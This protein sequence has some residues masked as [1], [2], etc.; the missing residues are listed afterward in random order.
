MKNFMKES[1]L[2]RLLTVFAV[3]CFSC[4]IAVAQTGNEEP[5]E[6]AGLTELEQRMQKRI[7]ID[8]NDQPI[9]LVIRQL[10]EQANLNY[11]KS[12]NVIGNVTVTFRDVPLEE[13]LRN[14]LD[15]HG[16]TYVPTE[17]VIRIITS[18]EM[19]TKAEPILTET[20]EI[21]YAD[22]EKVVEALDKSK[23]P[24]GSVSFIKGTSYIIV[25]DTESKIR[26]I[27]ELLEK[28]DRITPQI[29]VEARI[30]DITS[31]DKLDLGVDWYAGRRTNWLGGYPINDDIT[32]EKS[33]VDTYLGSN[34]DPSIM[35]GFT[36]SGAG[37]T[38][39]NTL[40][41]LNLGLLNNN[42]DINALL[43]AEQEITEAKLLANPRIL[44]LDNEQ[45]LF[46]IV[47]EHPYV[48][49]TISGNQITETVQFK[50]VGIKLVV[51]P[52]VTREGM[53]RLHILPEFGVKVGQV[54]VS[55]NNVPIVDTRKVDTIALVRDGQTVVLGGMRQK[56]VSKQTN[57]IPLLGDLPLLGGL[58][59]F[60]GED[61]AVTE[62]IV[63]ITPW[64]V[65]QEPV[66]SL[67]EQNALEETNFSRPKPSST[68]A[69]IK[70]AEESS[71]E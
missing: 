4:A 18:E 31:R 13:A 40:G 51:T 16:C 54:L 9:D 58:F 50:D 24:Q 34:T 21:V 62:L 60:D 17:N 59:R 28:I 32:V 7:S 11:I 41:Y 12:P 1:L 52:H 42:I 10:V 53:L 19:V 69:E 36:G 65:P 56:A 20:F 45:A 6:K 39:D 26:K 63:F 30:Y 66:L 48:E 47:T 33:G 57:K 61:T 27:K 2:L 44:V 38:D 25:T 55:S 5:K 22:A 29:L 3:V 8:V 14:I 43:K 37:K 23:S 67:D 70:I 49:R 68:K 71:E 15:V 46:D 35:S 64:I